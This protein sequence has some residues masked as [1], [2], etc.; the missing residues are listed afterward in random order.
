MKYETKPNIPE[1]KILAIP[2]CFLSTVDGGDIF[3]NY[4]NVNKIL[5]RDG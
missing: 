4:L 2:L 1:P 5:S 3:N